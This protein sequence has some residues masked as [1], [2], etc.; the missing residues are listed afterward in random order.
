[1][2]YSKRK[3]GNREPPCDI[4]MPE[5]MPNNKKA[6]ELYSL[7]QTQLVVIGMGEVLDINFNAIEFIMNLYNVPNKKEVFE[8]IVKVSRYF[9]EENKRKST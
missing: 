6:L 1:M 9:I 2:I 8:K 3:K 4:C 7:V 5:I